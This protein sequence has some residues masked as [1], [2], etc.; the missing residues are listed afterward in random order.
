MLPFY[1]LLSPIPF[2]IPPPTLILSF[3]LIVLFP[4]L[5]HPPFKPL[6]FISQN[7]G[8][9]SSQPK[10]SISTSKQNPI[11]DPFLKNEQ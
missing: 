6:D 3:F 4:L 9:F 2:V 5:T 11:K 7:H 10:I 1:I 8:S